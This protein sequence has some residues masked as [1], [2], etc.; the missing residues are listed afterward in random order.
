MN[1]VF[2]EDNFPLPANSN[3]AN[4]IAENDSLRRYLR[5]PFR[6]K[7]KLVAVATGII[8]VN[9]DYGSKNVVA[10][11]NLR[12]ANTMQEPD[13]VLNED[14]YVNEGDQLVLNAINE[15]AGALNILYRLV[16]DPW[17]G[18][19]P[20]DSRTMQ[21]GPIAVPDGAADQQLLDGT[22]YERPPVHCFLSTFMTSSATGLLRQL[23]V[24]TDSIAPP[25]DVNPSNRIPLDPF[26]VSITEVQV[27]EDKL[28]SLSVSNNSGGALN[29]FWKTVLKELF[30]S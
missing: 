27:P 23:Y 3:I 20:P 6:A 4:V 29:V 24:D 10:N 1:P 12:V 25:S 11:S 2:I 22:R 15:T 18:E 14:F 8:M 30:R 9:F 28:I 16:L 13:D 21:Q 17:E 26:D 5:A 19:F 7:G